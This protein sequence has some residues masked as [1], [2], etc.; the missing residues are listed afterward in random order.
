MANE[1]DFLELYRQLR[2]S[3]DCSL[4]E[5]KRAYRRCVSTLHPDRKPPGHE[6]YKNSRSGQR[7]QQLN[8]QYEAAMEFHRLHGRLPGAPP[9]S[10]VTPQRVNPPPRP[11]PPPPVMTQASSA[12]PRR[13]HVKWL[14][15][16]ALLAIC[17]LFWGASA[18]TPPS[19]GGNDNATRD[20]DATLAEAPAAP[21]LTLGMSPENVRT[22]EGN[23]VEIRDDL[24]EYGP[25]W[26][27]FDHGSVIDWYSSPL[28][29]LK[30]AQARPPTAHN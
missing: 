23:P 3:P 29:S 14:I 22:I 30:T 27:R 28:H 4:E 7:L 12:V 26:I 2:V 20:N 17:I 6:G 5:F 10:V 24:W 13:P 9:P 16:I 1:I 15:P 21:T 8:V 25:S 18:V 19:D 11:P